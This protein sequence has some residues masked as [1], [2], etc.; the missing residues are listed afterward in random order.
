MSSEGSL[1]KPP[2]LTEN[3]VSKKIEGKSE[4]ITS[5]HLNIVCDNLC[6]AWF[7]KHRFRLIGAWFNRLL[8]STRLHFRSIGHTLYP[9]SGRESCLGFASCSIR[10]SDIKR[11]TFS[12]SIPA[13]LLSTRMRITLSMSFRIYVRYTELTRL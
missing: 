2:I 7:V 9:A 10:F 3:W 5:P 1:G 6:G 4:S 11:C 12:T 13:S 8:R